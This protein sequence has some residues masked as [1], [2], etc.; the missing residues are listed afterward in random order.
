MIVEQGKLYFL[1]WLEVIDILNAGHPVYFRGCYT[2][3][4]SITED[5]IT[6]TNHVILPKENFT[7]NDIYL[8][9]DHPRYFE[10]YQK[11]LNHH[12][13]ILDLID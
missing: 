9:C 7:I 3:I 5:D 2:K 10:L 11:Y 1:S 6:F 8:E 4:E 13:D 12:E